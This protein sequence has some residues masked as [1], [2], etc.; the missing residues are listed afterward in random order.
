MRPVE[1]T[2]AVA[3]GE[4]PFVLTS[5]FACERYLYWIRPGVA[6]AAVTEIEASPPLR[7]GDVVLLLILICSHDSTTDSVFSFSGWSH[8]VFLIWYTRPIPFPPTT[9]SRPGCPASRP[10]ARHTSSSSAISALKN[11]F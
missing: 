4:P 2:A 10:F 7:R 11:R 1:T 9:T 8:S 5:P 6:P 3:I